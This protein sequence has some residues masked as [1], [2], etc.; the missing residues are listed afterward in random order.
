LNTKTLIETLRQLEPTKV[1]W[2]FALYNAHKSRDGVELDWNQCKMKGVAGWIETLKL[3]LLE[4]TL[5]EKSVKE[6]SPFLSDKENIGAL[7]KKD[8]VICEQVTD[9]LLSVKNALP[10][11]PE[12]FIDGSLPKITGYAFCGEYKIET[13]ESEKTMQIIFMRRSNP[14]IS[15]AKARLCTSKGGDVVYCDKPILKF[16][17]AVDFIMID[18]VCYF[19]SSAIEKDLAMENR[20]F[21]IA[22]NRLELIAAVEI[23]SD[24]EK[25]ESAVM[26][27][28]NAKK[29]ITFDEQILEHI[30]SMPI[31][32]RE[33]FLLTYGIT[34]DHKGTMDTSDAEQCELIIDLLCC[35]SVVDPLGRLATANNITPRE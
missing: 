25:L 33:D 8:E 7:E 28:K 23:V 26:T 27:P 15:T 34:I 13:E 2:K 5:P 10:Y 9:I 22:V 35:R 29:F 6:Y 11:A 24:F 21:A 12:N 32:E 20:Y 19:L 4:K 16:T 1:D 30:T 17:T 3:S 18:D 14:F 31:L